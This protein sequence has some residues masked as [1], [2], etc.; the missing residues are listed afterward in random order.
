[1]LQVG[2][3][4][5]AMP[6]PLCMQG[7]FVGETKVGCIIVTSLELPL[8][9]TSPGIQQNTPHKQEQQGVVRILCDEI[10]GGVGIDTNMLS[11]YAGLCTETGV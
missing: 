3:L 6:E 7:L 9:F 8:A 10:E 5:R 11:W 2:F 1:M 4:L